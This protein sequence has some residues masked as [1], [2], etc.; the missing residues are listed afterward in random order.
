MILR[1]EYTNK[2]LLHSS[3]S[4]VS[5][6]V[7]LLLVLEAPARAARHRWA[8]TIMAGIY[9]LFTVLM[10]WI[11]P[12][13]PASPKLGPVY[14]NITHMVPLP[15]P[16]L[17][18]I[19]AFVLD[20]LWPIVPT[21]CRKEDILGRRIALAAGPFRRR[22]VYGRIGRRAVAVRH[23]S[24]VAGGTQLVLSSGQLSVFHSINAATV[25]YV[26]VKFDDTAAQFWRGMG[27]ACAFSVVSLWVGIVFG[28]W[29]KRIQR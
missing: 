13:F 19:P 1:L 21:G 14:Q 15:W 11:L 22:R 23:F 5:L 17:L 27:L 29:L 26:F 2:V 20:L 28:D 7:G 8:R 3:V 16:I 10:L 4:Y 24:H 18:V 6:G 25:R 9:S 12:L